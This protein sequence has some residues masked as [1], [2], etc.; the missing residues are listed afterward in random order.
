MTPISAK[1]SNVWMSVTAGP[2][3][4]GLYCWSEVHAFLRAAKEEPWDDL[5]RLALADWLEERGDAERSEFLRLQCRLGP[6]KQCADDSDD[7][8]EGC[9]AR[10]ALAAGDAARAAE[11]AAQCDLLREI[12]GPGPFRPVMVDPAWLAHDDV[13]KKVTE[14]LNH[15]RQSG[16]YVRGCWALNAVRRRE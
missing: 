8:C 15:L 11:Q 3:V 5:P 7:P 2:G 4:S 12:F 9:V 14:V 6:E 1:S 13:M 10:R 16:S